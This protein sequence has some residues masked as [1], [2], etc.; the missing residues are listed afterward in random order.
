MVTQGVTQAGQE[1]AGERITAGMPLQSKGYL[2]DLHAKECVLPHFQDQVLPRFKK[3]KVIL[4]SAV[5]FI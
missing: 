4:A 1:L 3:K 5:I 2:P